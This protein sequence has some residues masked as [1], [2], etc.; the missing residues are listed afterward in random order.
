MT[1]SSSV[2]QGVTFS[3]LPGE[4]MLVSIDTPLFAVY[5]HSVRPPCQPPADAPTLEGCYL[6]REHRV[7]LHLRLSVPFSIAIMQ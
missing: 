3:R 5:G 2:E 7:P 4:R 1:P 6:R